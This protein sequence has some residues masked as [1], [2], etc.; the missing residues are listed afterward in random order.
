M[1]RPWN[2]RRVQRR[3]LARLQGQRRPAMASG[4]HATS[5]RNST[6]RM[7]ARSCEAYA[8]VVWTVI[9]KD[10]CVVG[11]TGSH[12]RSC[13]PLKTVRNTVRETG[14]DVERVPGSATARPAAA[15]RAGHPDALR[16]NAATRGRRPHY[17]RQRRRQASNPQASTGRTACRSRTQPYPDRLQEELSEDGQDHWWDWLRGCRRESC[18]TPR[19]AT[20]VVGLAALE[21]LA[22]A[23]AGGGRP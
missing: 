15:G 23:M 17:R 9:S 14:A 11:K 12:K 4:S 7:I 13:H 10:V 6:V 21:T 8:H 16:D 18:R 22:S 19:V 1:A 2:E 3:R 5:I 20:G